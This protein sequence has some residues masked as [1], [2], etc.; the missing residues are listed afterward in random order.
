VKK[1]STTTKECVKKS[2]NERKGPIGLKKVRW[3]ITGDLVA[4]FCSILY[5][6]RK[7]VVAKENSY[8]ANPKNVWC[9]IA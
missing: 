7:T 9:K 1:G 5:K 8:D 6:N 3:D 2:H 4:I